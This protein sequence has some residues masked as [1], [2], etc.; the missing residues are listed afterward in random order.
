MLF[1]LLTSRRQRGSTE[2]EYATA[3]E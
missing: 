1:S 3:A 2:T